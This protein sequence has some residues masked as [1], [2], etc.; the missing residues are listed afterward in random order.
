MTWISIYKKRIPKSRV[1]FY[2]KSGIFHEPGSQKTPRHPAV[3]DPASESTPMCKISLKSIQWKLFKSSG[4][5]LYGIFVNWLDVNNLCFILTVFWPIYC[6][7]KSLCLRTLD[8]NITAR[9]IYAWMNQLFLQKN[10]QLGIFIVRIIQGS[11]YFC[12]D[13]KL[14]ISCQIAKKHNKKQFKD[15][16]KECMPFVL[17]FS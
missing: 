10:V 17:S 2:L 12:H 9:K 5:I 14:N 6:G 1:S 15:S 8:C 16:F 11:W 13:P 3:L 4:I 7:S